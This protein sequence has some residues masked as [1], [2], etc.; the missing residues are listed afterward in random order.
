MSLNLKCM[1]SF[2]WIGIAGLVQRHLSFSF[3]F[4]HFLKQY[5]TQPDQAWLSLAGSGF[6]KITKMSLWISLVYLSEA[7]VHLVLEFVKI[8]LKHLVAARGGWAYTQL[9]QLYSQP[10]SA[11]L[12]LS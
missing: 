11:G 6:C 5:Y 2:S 12:K 8:I 7:I 9:R 3:I 10:D 1:L 4:I